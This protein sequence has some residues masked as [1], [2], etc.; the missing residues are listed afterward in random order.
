MG[1]V[2]PTSKVAKNLS[3]FKMVIADDQYYNKSLE[4][5]RD[6]LSAPSV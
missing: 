1:N 4:E 5:R 2:K 6:I 3:S